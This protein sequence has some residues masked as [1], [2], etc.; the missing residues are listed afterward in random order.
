VGRTDHLWIPA[1]ADYAI[2][3]LVA[4]AGSAKPLTADT[5]ARERA[6]PKTYL[7]VILA[8]LR[9]GGLVR[10]RRGRTGGYSLA[11]DPAEISLAAV[12][13]A[14]DETVDR[15]IDL[16]DAALN[17]TYQVI[18]GSLVGLLDTVSVAELLAGTVPEQ[19]R[20]LAAHVNGSQPTP[21]TRTRKRLSPRGR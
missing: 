3:A 14:V 7:T 2:R 9:R 4:L 15:P 18:R 20:D 6:V 11:K 19:I 12:L 8:E 5:I 10:S 21:V 13:R 17:P 1:R 16:T